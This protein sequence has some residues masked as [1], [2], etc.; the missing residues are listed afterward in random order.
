MSSLGKVSMKKNDMS[1]IKMKSGTYI[2]IG[3]I[4]T[5]LREHSETALR[6]KKQAS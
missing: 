2:D 6:N 4:P 5:K 1:I 3:Y